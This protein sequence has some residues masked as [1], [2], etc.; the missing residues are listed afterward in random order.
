VEQIGTPEEVYNRPKSEF[1]AQ[2]LGASNLLAAR[3]LGTD[4]IH[5]LLETPEFGQTAVPVANSSGVSAGD[6]AKLMIRAEKLTLQDPALEGVAATVE[7]VD[8]QGQLARYFV[9]VGDTQLQAI[10]MIESVPFKAG[11]AVSLALAADTCSALAA[12]R[13]T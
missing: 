10:N 8:Y 12:E 6:K 9:R 3:V 13:K 7:A 11:D 1:V 2:F 4:A 5:V